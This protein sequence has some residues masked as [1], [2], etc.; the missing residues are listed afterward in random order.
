MTSTLSELVALTEGGGA[1]PLMNIR[2]VIVVGVRGVKVNRSGGLVVIEGNG[3]KVSFRGA[4]LTVEGETYRVSW[5]A[6]E[7]LLVRPVSLVKE[8]QKT[9]GINAATFARI[10]P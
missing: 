3:V 1:Q 8:I 2:K 4:T 10:G 7:A 6:Y 9:D 5:P